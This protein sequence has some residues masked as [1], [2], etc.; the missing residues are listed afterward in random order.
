MQIQSNNAF[1]NE[2]QKKAKERRLEN[3]SLKKRI[4]EL[5]ISRDGWK[6]K[7]QSFQEQLNTASIKLISLERAYKKNFKQKQK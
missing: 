1:N 6:T 3:K 5:T 4:K 2:W 7:A